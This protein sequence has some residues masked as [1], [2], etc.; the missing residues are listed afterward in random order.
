M[1]GQDVGQL[2]ANCARWGWLQACVHTCLCATR[3]S[4]WPLVSGFKDARVV[5]QGQ[6]DKLFLFPLSPLAMHNIR[7]LKS[8]TTHLEI[9]KLI[10]PANKTVV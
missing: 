2:I 7:R 6:L 1:A 9:F 4:A 3:C 8:N 5:Q 10:T